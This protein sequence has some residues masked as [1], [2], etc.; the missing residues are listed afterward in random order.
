[1][2]NEILIRLTHAM[3]RYSLLNRENWNVDK[4]CIPINQRDA[5][6][7]LQTFNSFPIECSKQLDLNFSP[8]EEEA[9]LHMWNVSGYCL[10]VNPSLLPDSVDDAA[11]L[12]R[13]ILRDCGG[14]N[15]IGKEMT[16]NLLKSYVNATPLKF[17]YELHETMIRFYLGDVL[18]ESLGIRPTIWNPYLVPT[19][20]K[21]LPSWEICVESSKTI[22]SFS[23]VFS[24][25]FLSTMKILL[26]HGKARPFDISDKLKKE[27]N[28]K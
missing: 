19:L 4:F 26:G 11:G 14:V 15:P 23:G 1:M 10:G 2:S 28:I 27:L 24:R 13:S 12:C 18:A 17:G 16:A 5:S 6:G 20:K 21:V 8:E 7:T 22:G 25:F 9:Y 3:V